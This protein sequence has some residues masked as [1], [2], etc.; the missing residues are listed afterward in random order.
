MRRGGTRFKGPGHAAFFYW[1]EKGKSKDLTQRT[2]RKAT[3][4]TEE[5]KAQ[6]GGR[7]RLFG[8]G[9]FFGEFHGFVEAAAVN[10]RHLR[11]HRTQV[12]G[13]LTA[14][15]NRVVQHELQ[16]EHG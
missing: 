13:E 5:A 12:C 1:C 14:V 3:E 15:M 4:D 6:G 9:G 11:T 2:R 10:V 8:G 16:V 7:R